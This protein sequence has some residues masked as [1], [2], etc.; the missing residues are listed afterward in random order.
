MTQQEKNILEDVKKSIEDPVYWVSLNYS[1]EKCEEYYDKRVKQWDNWDSNPYSNQW[2]KRE[3]EV[4]P[5]NDLLDL[6]DAVKQAKTLMNNLKEKDWVKK[7]NY[8]VKPNSIVV[9]WYRLKTF[10]EW[11]ENGLEDALEKANRDIY[12]DAR[13]YL[14]N[15]CGIDWY[16]WDEEIAAFASGLINLDTL[17]FLH[18]RYPTK[19]FEW[20][21][22]K[23]DIKELKRILYDKAEVP[24]KEIKVAVLTF[25]K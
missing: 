2:A 25:K 21:D 6:P 15:K 10:D 5:F 17:K 4:I 22:M 12:A 11:L 16:I 9:T 3:E 18:T 20:R 19:R 14:H 24:E 1:L 7:V 8:E 13:L 23:E